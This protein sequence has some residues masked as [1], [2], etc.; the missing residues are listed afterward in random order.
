VRPSLQFQ[1]LPNH[2]NLWTAYDYPMTVYSTQYK[3]HY[4][5]SPVHRPAERCWLSADSESRVASRRCNTRPAECTC[6]TRCRRRPHDSPEA[7]EER[8]TTRRTTGRT[9]T[10]TTGWSL[11]PAAPALSK[12]PAMS[13]SYLRQQPTTPSKLESHRDG[14]LYGLV[15]ISPRRPR[16]I[17]LE[18]HPR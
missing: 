11:D 12:A 3:L 13:S 10:A 18:G 2:F 16:R 17:A 14:L 6:R 7:A 1:T 5:G 9:T 4:I 8:A 15:L